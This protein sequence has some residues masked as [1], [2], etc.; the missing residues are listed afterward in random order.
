MDK[1]YTFVK[2]HK[3]VYEWKIKKISSHFKK[4]EGDSTTLKS[5][6]FSTGAKINDKWLLKLHFNNGTSPVYSEK[7]MSIFLY[8]LNNYT[9]TAEVKFIMF[10]TEQYSGSTEQ[11]IVFLKNIKNEFKMNAGQ[12]CDE[13]IR[14]EYL[15]KAKSSLIPDDVLTV[16]V[17]VIVTDNVSTV[18]IK[19]SFSFSKSPL[20]DDIKKLY[21]NK[22]DTD[23]TI[24]IEEKEFQAHRTMIMVRS[25]VLGEVITKEWIENKSKLVYLTGISSSIFEKVLEYIYTDEVTDLDA[26]AADLLEASDKY[27]LLS[28]KKICEHSLCTTLKCDDVVK[29]MILAGRH[30]ARQLLDYITKCIVA[31]ASNI[32][33]TDDYKELENSQPS[34]GFLMFKKIVSSLNI[35][36][37]KI[38]YSS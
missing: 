26:V 2:K 3:I 18:P 15:L 35:N 11:C 24:V 8:N 25:P 21:K 12:G 16:G 22:E 34:L 6:E 38:T 1:G 29:R 17:E 33:E 27:Q 28:L 13:F 37:S 19:S 20:V 9:V 23:V 5:S 30:N 14:K 10:H 32:M 31:D 4:I 36:N 7:Y